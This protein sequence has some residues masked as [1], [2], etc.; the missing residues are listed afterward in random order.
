M[1]LVDDDEPEVAERQEQR[2]AGADDQPRVAGGN[3]GPGA[4]AGGLGDAR[5]PLGRAG[6]EACLDPVEELGREGDLGQEH[7]RL[8]AAAQRLGHRLEVDLGLARAGDALEQRRR[9]GAGPHRRGERGRRLGLRRRERQRPGA[10]IEPRIGGVARRRLAH[11]HALVLEAP[12]HARRDA[13]GLSELHRGEPEVAVLLE[14]GEDARARRRQPVRNSA[15]V[16]QDRPGAGR[17]PEAGRSRGEPEHDRERGQRVL[18]GAG[19]EGAHRRRERRRVEDAA[20]VAQLR[21]VEA[22]RAFAPDHA[23]HPARPERHL[24]EVAGA[25][26]SGRRA[27][28]ERPVE[29]FGGDHRDRGPG[30]EFPH[31]FG[32]I[33]V[34]HRAIPWASIPPDHKG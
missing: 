27:V 11:E 4:A 1:L 31:R 12:D 24:D 28:V 17:R 13:G 34:F 26:A 9:V 20:D 33:E 2:R 14:R 25:R 22:A 19:E 16:A 18:G 7:Q 5:V 6:A 8:A 23:E 3:R 10:G 29:P 15:G 21:R 30:R 32:R